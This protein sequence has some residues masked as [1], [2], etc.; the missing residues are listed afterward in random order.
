MDLNMEMSFRPGFWLQRIC[1]NDHL[2]ILSTMI[3][4][5]ELPEKWWMAVFYLNY[6]S[7][8]CFFMLENKAWTHVFPKLKGK[9]LPETRS[10]GVDYKVTSYMGLLFTGLVIILLPRLES[11]VAQAKWSTSKQSI[12]GIAI[13]FKHSTCMCTCPNTKMSQTFLFL[14]DVWQEFFFFRI[15]KQPLTVGGPIKALSHVMCTPYQMVSQ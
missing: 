9:S 15:C 13:P 3:L 8:T 5:L 11:I 14:C 12:Q 6:C 7:L 4:S 1:Y 10:F 2:K